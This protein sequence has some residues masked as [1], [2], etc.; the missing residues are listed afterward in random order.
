MKTFLHRRSAGIGFDAVEPQVQEKKR[1]DGVLPVP[2]AVPVFSA[3]A[4]SAGAL[5]IGALSIGALAIG[6]VAIA[7]LVIGRLSIKKAKI[8]TLEV[9][10]LR[11]GRLEAPEKG[12]AEATTGES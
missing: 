3:G 7:R 1:Y 10:T 6:A 11:V 12:G 8:G 9:G 4:V 2:K 5:A